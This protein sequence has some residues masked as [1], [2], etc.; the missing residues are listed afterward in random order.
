[1]IRYNV[2]LL[3]TQDSTTDF[4]SLVEYSCIL[5]FFTHVYYLQELNPSKLIIYDMNLSVIYKVN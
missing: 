2:V 3:F 1:M 5:T 4:E